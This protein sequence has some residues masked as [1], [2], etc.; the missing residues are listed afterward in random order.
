MT[1]RKVIKRKR[2][3]R[4]PQGE[5]SKLDSPFSV[6][7]PK[8]MRAELNAAAKKSGRTAGQELLGRLRNS[9]YRDRDKSRDP[10]LRA[11]CFLIGELAEAAATP[12]P[13]PVDK[14]RPFWR[15]DPFLYRA[16]K[17]AVV[18]LLDALEPAGDVHAP[19]TE[20]FV[21]DLVE[22]QETELYSKLPSEMLKSMEKIYESPETL[23]SHIFSNIWSGLLGVSSP[24]AEIMKSEMREILSH[25][26][27]H[28][29]GEIDS[30]W[31][32][33]LYGM[34]DAR[35]DLQIKL[36]GEKS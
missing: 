36:K 17:L 14:L 31:K 4:K 6:R 19:I 3:G 29:L 34:Q 20:E 28:L 16:F 33:E 32:D 9:F 35:R 5:F 2:A 30:M 12:G 18:K 26:Y 1:K 15:T 25:K 27:P 21:R 8:S 10:A 11:L 24:D 7:M 23:S 13:L 22:A